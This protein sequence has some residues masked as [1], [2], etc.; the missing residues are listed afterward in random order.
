ML[1]AAQGPK[2][3]TA[4][5]RNSILSDAKRGHG[6]GHL[7]TRLVHRHGS[8][9]FACA[10]TEGST[11]CWGL[12]SNL[13]D[14]ASPP[15][16]MKSADLVGVDVAFDDIAKVTIGEPEDTCILSRSGQVA[17]N[18][19]GVIAT[20]AVDVAVGAG[21]CVLL[22]DADGR[23]IECN[24]GK[25]AK[26][27]LSDP[28]AVPESLDQSYATCAVSTDHLVYCYDNRHWRNFTEWQRIAGL[29]DVGSVATSCAL[30][31]NGEV[32]CWGW[33]VREPGIWY[34][35]SDPLPAAAPVVGLH[36]RSLREGTS[37]ARSRASPK[38]GVGERMPDASSAP[39]R[40]TRACPS[41][42]SNS[43]Q[44]RLNE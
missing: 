18:G 40:A 2:A 32:W 17:C 38:Y 35:P 22:E 12:W 41:R 19:A 37:S 8:A 36:G 29:D 23:S 13:N 43:S 28:S 10:V 39:R 3:N 11:S 20:N 30:R 7:E 14:D 42:C 15:R 31:V 24:N 33:F 9:L 34:E 26:I 27:I 4:C 16:P 5:V 25:G 1:R 6:R 21:I 44:S